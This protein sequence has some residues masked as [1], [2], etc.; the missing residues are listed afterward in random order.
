MESRSRTETQSGRPPLF[1]YCLNTELSELFS[2]C[3]PALTDQ[4]AIRDPELLAFAVLIIPLFQSIMSSLR[5]LSA[6]LPTPHAAQDVLQT[7]PVMSRRQTALSASS[8][9]LVLSGHAIRQ[10]LSLKS[11]C[12]DTFLAFPLL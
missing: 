11:R 8:D 5:L 6:A 1:D 4:T 7:S 12:R 9:G 10:K 3:L 2:E